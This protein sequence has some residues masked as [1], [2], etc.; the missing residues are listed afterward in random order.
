[1]RTSGGDEYTST[2]FS[3]FCEKEGIEYEVI[4]TY[5]LSQNDTVERKNIIILNMTRSM[6]KVRHI[7][8]HFWGKAT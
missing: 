2:E 3:Q 1:M 6:I 7:P 8:N 5:T 4:T